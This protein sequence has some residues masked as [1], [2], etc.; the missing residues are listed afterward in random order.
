[1]TIRIGLAVLLLLV[2]ACSGASS[3]P[4]VDQPIVVRGA[5]LRHGVLPGTPLDEGGVPSELRIVSVEN[6]ESII[7]LG[8]VGK[9]F[10]G[11]AAGDVA[12]IGIALEGLGDSYWV[13][14]VGAPDL[15]NPGTY[16]FDF[17]ADFGDD[18]PSGT[19]QLSVVAIDSAGN[20]GTIFRRPVCFL[21]DV[22]DNGAAC[23]VNATLPDTVISLTWGTDVDLDLVIVTPTGK[24]VS[25]KH[26]NTIDADS[27]LTQPQVNDPSN[28]QL[29]R[30]SN[31][32]C[33]ID[34]V[35]RESLVFDGPPPAG[36]YRVYARLSQ[37]CGHGSTTYAVE[38][39]RLD[40]GAL[41]RTDRIR[42]DFLALQATGPTGLGV[43]VTELV[44]P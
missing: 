37:A 38:T 28:G 12:A 41:V 44:L 8:Q 13:V 15:N 32:E 16:L 1:M 24:V 14:P 29:T 20:A 10:T 19:Q 30:D 9:A 31:G 26:P 40:A 22:P 43:F 39:Y 7:R 17:V 3:D 42:G 11:R 23:I 21:P 4:G 25:L 18:V 36:T 34:S 27:G 33:V 6:A 35:R 5:Q 2:S